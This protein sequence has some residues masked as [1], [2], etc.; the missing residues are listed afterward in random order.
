MSEKLKH[1]FRTAID[2]IVSND[3]LKAKE[4]IQSAI[5]EHP[6][7]VSFNKRLEKYRIAQGEIEI[8]E[9]AVNSIEEVLK[10]YKKNKALRILDVVYL[11]IAKV[12]DGMRTEYV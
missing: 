6:T 12:D 1:K 3:D 5:R 7:F 11:N 10:N 8:P 9:D 4:L 2:L